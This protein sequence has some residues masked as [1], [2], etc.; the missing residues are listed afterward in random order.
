MDQV[1]E[2]MN[3]CKAVHRSQENS[4]TFFQNENGPFRCERFQQIGVIAQSQQRT[5]KRIQLFWA[6]Q[7]IVKL[8]ANQAMISNCFSNSTIQQARLAATSRPNQQTCCKSSGLPI[9]YS[10]I[11]TCQLPI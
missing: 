10:L 4:L 8:R 6:E 5:K 2:M 3:H 11:D 1:H 7:P 9:C